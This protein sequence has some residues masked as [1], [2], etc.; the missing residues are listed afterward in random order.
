[1][2][3]VEFHD[4]SIEVK[5]ALAD[6]AYASL[7][8]AAGEIESQVKRNTKVD[9]GQLKNSWSHRV[10]GSMM[11]GEH[12]ARIGSPLESAIWQ[13]FGTGEFALNDDGRKGGWF[14]EDKWGVGHFTYG[15]K[16]RRS[17]YKAYTKLKNRI[18]KMIQERFKG[19]G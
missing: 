8:E 16:P 13:E 1:M 3:Q 11:A 14:Y 12:E 5:E 15:Q 18:I 19:L 7:E 6:A 17:L 9:T 2:A 4:Y 10:T